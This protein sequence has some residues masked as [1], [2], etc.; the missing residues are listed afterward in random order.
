L[1]LQEDTFFA[2]VVG[3]KLDEMLLAR[4]QLIIL[5]ARKV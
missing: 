3:V 2:K 1:L 4:K 5:L